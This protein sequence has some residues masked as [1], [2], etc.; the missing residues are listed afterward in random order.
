MDTLLR[1]L[2]FALRQLRRT[3]AF[4]VAAVACLALGIGANTAIFSAVD[5]VLLR[6]LP[7]PEPERLVTI[8]GHHASIGRESAS[9]PDFLDWRR[10]SRSFSGMAA[11]ANT[12]F[13]LTGAGEPEVVRGALV[14]ANYFRVLGASDPGRAGLPRRRGTGRRRPGRDAERR[15]LAAR[16]RRPRRRGGPPDHARRGALHDRGRRAR[17]ACRLPEDVD[18]WA[19]VPTDTTLGR[20]NDFLEVVGRLAPGADQRRRGR[21]ADDDRP[22]AGAGLPGQQQRLGRRAGRAAGAHRGRDPAG[23]ARLHGRGRRWCC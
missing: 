21:G 15:V 3:P 7:F 20:R 1:D 18:V 6:P 10:E 23:A 5:G 14:T 22:A 17:G 11:Q 8:W 2:R 13:I 9:L 12:Q 19:T 16:V 4:T